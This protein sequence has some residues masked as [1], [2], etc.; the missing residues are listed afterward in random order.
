MTDARN[1]WVG[2]DGQRFGPYDEATLRAWIAEGKVEATAMGWAE[3]MAEWQPLHVLLGIAVPPPMAGRPMPPAMPMTGPMVAPMHG[4]LPP[5]PDIPW[6]VIFIVDLFAGGLMGLVWQF[7][8]SAWIKKIDP[9]SKATMW[10]VISLCLLP[11]GWFLM[12][13][14]ALNISTNGQPD[15]AAVAGMMSYFSFFGLV[16]LASFVVRIVGYF[17]MARSMREV[18]PRHGLV[19]DIGGVTLFFFSVYY[20]QGQMSWVARWRQTGQVAPPA[21]RNVFW[22]LLAAWFGLML[23][24]FL[25][26]GMALLAHGH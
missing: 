26:I 6:F 15:V 21:P 10:L 24:V 11:L 14:M 20:L 23:L 1:I 5:P 19:P 2:R 13:G 9:T 4:E 25:T 22:I 3:G 12:M 7:L 17:A 18:L 16:V 8:Q